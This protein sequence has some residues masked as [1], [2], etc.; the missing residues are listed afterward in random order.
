MRA[1]TGF[2]L[3]LALVLLTISS[4]FAGAAVIETAAPLSEQSDDSVKVAVKSAVENAVKG[5][6]AM[7]LTQVSL[8]GV[9]V[10]PTMVIVRI[11]AT[12]SQMEEG[13]QGDEPEQMSDT[14]PECS[15]AHG[16]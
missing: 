15:Q 13:A 12:D 7:G 8:H 2:A 16:A 9:R 10:L 6:K 5:A 3:A 14:A 4:V 1:F 11:L